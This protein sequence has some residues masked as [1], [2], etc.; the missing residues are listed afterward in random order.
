MEMGNDDQNLNQFGSSDE[1][2]DSNLEDEELEC[3]KCNATFSS[4][5]SGCSRVHKLCVPCNEKDKLQ[6]LPVNAKDVSGIYYFKKLF[7][8]ALQ[9]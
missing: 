7:L 6:N 8:L 4:N 9:L 5:L 3:K 2:E 1:E